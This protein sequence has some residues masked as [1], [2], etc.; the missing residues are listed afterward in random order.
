MNYKPLHPDVLAKAK[1]DETRLIEE[2]G[3]ELYDRLINEGW[4]SRQE[5]RRIVKIIT[6]ARDE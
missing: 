5:A 3:Q 1:Q 6:G 2:L 4:E